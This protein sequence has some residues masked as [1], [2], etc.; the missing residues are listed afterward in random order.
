[1]V[2][3]VN[4]GLVSGQAETEWSIG[5]PIVTYFGTGY[6]LTNERAQRMEEGGWNLAWVNSLA[7]LNV[8]YLHG[9]RGMWYG[10]LDDSTVTAIRSHPAL[11]SYFIRDEPPESMF[12]EMASTV[13]RLRTLDPEHLGYINLYPNYA[14]PS[15]SSYSQYLNEYISTV[16]P[17][18]LSYDHYQFTKTGD[19][20]DWFKNLA[21]VSHTAKE[22][23]L[24]FMVTVQSSSWDS[25]PNIRVPNGNELRY[26]YNTSLAY[27]AQGISDFVYYKY[28]G[29]EGGMANPDG[30]MTALY[31]A[32]K[33]INPEF[34]AIAQ[35][36]QSMHHIGTYHLG[37]L[38]PGYGTT[39]G[40]SPLRL[41]G[42]SPFTI[43]GITTTNY[44]AYQPVRGAVLGLYGPGD[45]LAAATCTLVVNLDY[46]NPLETRVTGPGDLSIFDPVT[47]MWIAQGHSW[48]DV[49]LLPGGSVL[50]GLTT[51]V[52]VP[53]PATIS[54]LALGGVALI[55]RKKS[56]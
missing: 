27:G 34:V 24:P 45:L 7:Q 53:E 3:A 9:L 35:E 41:P 16:Q 30:T 10:P 12:P 44:V 17:A 49:S 47:G 8:A 50:V 43:S 40:S 13:S 4:V 42:N 36:V 25:D 1:M 15:Y 20:P 33:T 46:S 54:L 28:D 31:D 32:A 37:D 38:P 21:I 2:L 26:L 23:G 22:A 19:T 18:I 14:Y 55:R 51:S 39:D 48:A 52:L 5:E 11:Y 6:A 29:F 56:S